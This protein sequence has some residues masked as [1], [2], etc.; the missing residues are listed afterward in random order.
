MPL[1]NTLKAQEHPLELVFPRKG[2]I[3]TSSQGMNSC[4]EE[5]LAPSLASL[6]VAGILCDVGDHSCIENALA[7]VLG[8]KAGVEVEIRPFQN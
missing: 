8:I 4:V 3:H 1:L 6:A 2:P 5:P 7:I